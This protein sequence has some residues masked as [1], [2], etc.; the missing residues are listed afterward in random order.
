MKKYIYLAAGL[1]GAFSGASGMEGAKTTYGTYQGKEITPSNLLELLEIE[2]PLDPHIEEQVQEFILEHGLVDILSGADNQE[3]FFTGLPEERKALADKIEKE[4]SE[5]GIAPLKAPNSFIFNIDDKWVIKRSKVY[6]ARQ[7]IVDTL[8][9]IDAGHWTKNAEYG[10][11]LTREEWGRFNAE[12]LN[13]RVYQNISRAMVYLRA[14]EGLRALGITNIYIP[15]T[16][17]IHIPGRPLEVEDRNYVVVET[18]Q[19]TLTPLFESPLAVDEDI[20]T[21]L[22][23]LT[24]Y[25][26][27]WTMGNAVS[28]G[29]DGRVYYHDHE[30]PN[31]HSII[32][33]LHR[34]PARFRELVRDG[35]NK[36]EEQIILPYARAHSIDVSELLERLH[37]IEEDIMSSWQEL[38][39]EITPSTSN[40]TVL[41]NTTGILPIH[42]LNPHTRTLE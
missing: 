41:S 25:T 13:G 2:A 29:P 17:L 22:V 14:R 10:R 18:F 30:L 5:K 23:R 38:S 33:I 32:D 31:R 16:H 19:G 20:L 28:V 42:E 11:A 21:S 3:I 40:T 12:P 34:D 39:R 7:N 26:G 6:I 8:T 35:W 27:W 37:R 36:L 9:S 15:E 24:A 4:L 1:L